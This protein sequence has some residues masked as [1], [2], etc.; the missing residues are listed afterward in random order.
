MTNSI[1]E[2]KICKVFISYTTADYYEADILRRRMEKEGYEVWF[3][4]QDLKERLSEE[5][6]AEIVNGIRNSNFFLIIVTQRSMESNEVRSE[7][8]LAFHFPKSIVPVRLD[9]AELGDVFAYFLGSRN[10]VEGQKPLTDDDVE[11]V[12]GSI[13]NL[14]NHPKTAE[15]IRIIVDDYIGRGEG[16]VSGERN[17]VK[18]C[19]TVNVYGIGQVH[20][21][22]VYVKP[23]LKR[24][25]EDNSV[26]TFGISLRRIVDMKQPM[27]IIAPA[28]YGKSLLSKSLVLEIIAKNKELQ[29]TPNE[30]IPF[31]IELG[32]EFNSNSDRKTLEDVLLNQI[33]LYVEK[34]KDVN[35][36]SHQLTKTDLYKLLESTKSVV[37]M[38]GLDEIHDSATVNGLFEEINCS[39][40]FNNTNFIFTSRPSPYCSQYKIVGKEIVQ[41]EILDFD[42]IQREEYISK[43]TKLQRM[44]SS[45]ELIFIETIKDVLPE[46]KNNPLML[47]Q[48]FSLFVSNKKIPSTKLGVYEKSVELLLDR[49]AK[50]E[51]MSSQDISQLKCAL[52]DIAG[53]HLKM[54]TTCLE[55]RVY[56]IVIEKTLVKRFGQN[57]DEARL[58]RIGFVDILNRSSMYVNG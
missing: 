38:D 39:S 4:P 21:S 50:R 55:E 19:S 57:R 22:S 25:D 30:E 7:L 18:Y 40:H 28:G 56:E 36:D 48:L 33:N 24:K 44:E 47:S 10:R 52:C 8:N 51:K 43:L 12:I 2:T 31:L 6:P 45:N 53:T 37:I 1:Q 11:R 20:I 26:A 32:K 29:D 5:Y 46:I 54:N 16:M 13:N 41:Y 15:M 14:I 35:G 27:L 17:I 42:D 23:R 49:V 9:R 34:L 3:A 58:K